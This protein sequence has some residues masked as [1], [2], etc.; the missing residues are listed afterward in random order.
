[1]KRRL[2]AAMMLSALAAGC[3]GGAANQAPTGLRTL[4][5]PVRILAERPS[6]VP[7]ALRRLEEA[8]GAG[9]RPIELAAAPFLALAPEARAFI[10]TPP[11]RAMAMGSPA[12]QCPMLTV[13]RGSPADAL[14]ACLQAAPAGADCGCQLLAVDDLLLADPAS[15]TYAPGVTA[16]LLGADAP[17][18]PLIVEERATEEPG[19]SLALFM[20]AAGPVALAELHADGLAR[21]VIIEDARFFE[22]EREAH[23]WRRGRKTERLLLRDD[24]G[25]RM[26]ALIGFEPAD[27]A[28]DGAA[29]AAWPRLEPTKG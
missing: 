12:A 24:E 13:V 4:S 27:M 20:D 23:G 29:L 9:S 2:G 19:V 22:G 14:E 18:R 25:R 8:R 16:R 3:A 1:M 28:E 5:D 21:L 26:I 11:P 17:R 15:F 7:A 6:G 10:E